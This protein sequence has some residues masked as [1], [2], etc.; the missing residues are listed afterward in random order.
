MWSVEVC[1]A[2]VDERLAELVAV[3]PEVELER[4][5]LFEPVGAFD[6]DGVDHV[7]RLLRPAHDD[8]A[9]LRDHRG[10]LERGIEE[11]RAG[12]DTFDR[13]E[14]KELLRGD[15]RTGQEHRAQLVLRHEPREVG[16][17]TERAAVDLGE[18]ER[19]VVGRDHDVGVAGESD[20]AAD[21]EALY[22]RDDGDLAV[23][24]G[25]E[26]FVTTS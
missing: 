25:G 19:R 11:L 24:H 9:L 23:V 1:V 20:T 3:S 18:A 4:E 12:Y 10:E 17:D 21:T 2:F 22:R 26:R 16:R 14:R 6:V 13:S 5:A 15:R 8:R 7:E